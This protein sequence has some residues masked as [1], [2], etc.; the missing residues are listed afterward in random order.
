ML[1]ENDSWKEHYEVVIYIRITIPTLFEVENRGCNCFVHDLSKILKITSFHHYKES[2]ESKLF[3]WFGTIF[4]R[5]KLLLYGIIMVEYRWPWGD[6]QWVEFMCSWLSVSVSCCWM[7]QLCDNV[8]VRMLKA[9]LTYSTA[10][11]TKD[12][13]IA[14][15]QEIWLCIR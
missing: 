4:I 2:S 9:G 5:R 14:F 8:V 11:C 6:F 12:R 3:F 1:L 15:T 13:K 10:P 7:I